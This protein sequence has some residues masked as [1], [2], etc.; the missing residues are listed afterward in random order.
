MKPAAGDPNRTPT[1]RLASSGSPRSFTSR[2]I[3][4]MRE[5]L[6]IAIAALTVPAAPPALQP[7]A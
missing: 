2:T 7:Y 5:A 4:F 1:I 6:T 3:T